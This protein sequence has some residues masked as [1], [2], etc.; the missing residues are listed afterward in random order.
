MRRVSFDKSNIRILLLEGVHPAG[1]E[2]LRAQGYENVTRLDHALGAEELA[3]RIADVH[4]LGIRSR[5]QISAHV[6]DVA[7]R[8]MALGCFCIGTNQVDLEAATRAG[9]PVF[10]AP[11]SNTRSVAE[12]VLA[13]AILLLRGVPRKTTE[14]HAGVW[15]KSA[16]AAFEVRGKTLGVIG[17]GNIGSQLGVLA[18]GLGMKVVFYDVEAKLKLGN[19]VQLPDLATLLRAADVISLHV[20]ATSATLRMINAHTL[21]LMKPGAV[22]INASRGDVVD[23]AALA[24]SIRAGRLLGAAIDVHPDEPGSNEDPYDSPLRGLANVIL[25]PHI[26]GS[27][28]EAQENIGL[29]VATKLVQYSDLGSTISC[30]CCKSKV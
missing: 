24:A 17:Y 14:M 13:E 1:M 18:E 6:L 26:G 10:N 30:S 5:S 21:P 20:P 7:P 15:R 23:L 22:L 25:T 8:L 4:M 2:R 27:T 11:Y 29:E 3:A 28:Q 9:I 19:A 12:L 16:R